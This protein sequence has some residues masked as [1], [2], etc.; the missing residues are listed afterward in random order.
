MK[1]AGAK[2]TH[3]LS[4]ECEART[5][6]SDVSDDNASVRDAEAYVNMDCHEESCFVG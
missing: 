3:S 6:V 5:G 1:P 2:L 4:K